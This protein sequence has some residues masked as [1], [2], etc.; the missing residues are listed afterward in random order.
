V[1]LVEIG[2]FADPAVADMARGRLAA[3]GIAALL[4]GAGLASLGLGGIAPVRLMV[5]AR[6][7]ARAEAVLADPSS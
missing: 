7:R 5:E 1:A 6:D 4:L 2:T 3:D